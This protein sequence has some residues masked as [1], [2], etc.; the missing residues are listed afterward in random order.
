MSLKDRKEALEKD[1]DHHRIVKGHSVLK[2]QSGLESV[3]ELSAFSPNFK[4]RMHK[5]IGGGVAG[6][7]EEALEGC[8]SKS[9][10]IIN[11]YIFQTP[12]VQVYGDHTVPQH[13]G[14]NA[15]P[16]KQEVWDP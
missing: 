11:Q 10:L 16:T 4:M 9:G 5:K 7:T 12:S 8:T 2:G 13:R 3:S 15:Y 1:R 6:W 14:F